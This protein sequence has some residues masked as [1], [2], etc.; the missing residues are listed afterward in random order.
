MICFDIISLFPNYFQS[1]LRESILAKAQE[2][3]FIRVRVHDL[4]S[5]TADKHHVTDDSP[6][7]GGVGMVLKPEPVVDALEHIRD[8]G[9]NARAVLLTPQ[10]E[11]FTQQLA[12]QLSCY[13]QLVLVCGRYEGVDERVR[14]FVDTEV[15]LG[16]YIING[17]E[18]AALV[19]V[20]AV[21][22]LVP[23]VLGK[24][25]STEGES[26]SAGL[27]EYPH[28]T[29]PRI[30]RGREVPETLISG[31]H[32]EIERWRLQESLKRTLLR[33]PDLLEHRLLSPEEQDLLKGI[34]QELRKEKVTDQ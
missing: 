6:Y 7:G 16:D 19:I 25:E 27:L 29:R 31:H 8:Q 13:E 5:F 9:G 4:R 20:E 17:G 18:A 12:E 30:F 28:Y 32:R 34:T 33:R 1:P 2:K 11:P 14:D 3:G 23:G 22:R 10:G 24:L 21:S 15:S 26:F